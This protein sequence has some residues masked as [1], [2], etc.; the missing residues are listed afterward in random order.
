MHYTRLLRDG[1]VGPPEPREGMYRI[2]NSFGYVA[3]KEPDHPL[4]QPST[5]RVLE[6]RKILY[7]HLGPGAHP[8]HWCGEVLT[9]DD[10]LATDHLDFD[11]ANNDL[12]NIVPS[13]LACNSRRQERWLTGD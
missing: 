3:L 2:I 9:W 12:A 7:E 8:C 13:C 1:D 6:H 10:G 11:R 4:A 5:G